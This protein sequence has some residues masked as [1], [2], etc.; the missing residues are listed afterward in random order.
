MCGGTLLFGWSVQSLATMAAA[1]SLADSAASAD[2]VATAVE[3]RRDN[4]GDEAAPPQRDTAAGRT[5]PA[6]WRML[7][8]ASVRRTMAS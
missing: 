4:A 7:K 6:A 5:K 2:E 3:A 8:L 1:A